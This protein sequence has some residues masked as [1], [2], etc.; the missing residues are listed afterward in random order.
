ME[1]NR[2]IVRNELKKYLS[3][4]PDISIKEYLK[5][6]EDLEFDEKNKEKER[7]DK[8]E[9]WYK[10]LEGKYIIID[11]NGS[12]FIAFYINKYP[13]TKFDNKYDCYEIYYVNDKIYEIRFVKNR[14]VNR[15]WFDNPFEK[16][17]YG[18]K[19]C[20]CWKEISKED[21]EKIKNIFT[22]SFENLDCFF[23]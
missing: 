4:Y 8:C 6:L 18:P 14:C 16:K 13:D 23:K 1:N 5:K 9:D 19:G 20:E 15:Y 7:E 11:F 3:N 10:E 12:S 22:T 21:F 2:N 17:Q